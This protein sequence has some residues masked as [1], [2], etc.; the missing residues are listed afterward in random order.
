VMAE[1]TSLPFAADCLRSLSPGSREP[2][3]TAG[4]DE[5]QTKQA[6]AV[7]AGRIGKD[8]VGNPDYARH[9]RNIGSLMWLWKTYGSADEMTGYLTTRFTD[10]PDEAVKFLDAFIGRAY[11]LENGLSHKSTFDRNDFDNVALLVAPDVV[12]N[13]LEKSYGALLEAV[14][15]DKC[16]ELHGDEQTACRF[17]AIF[18]NVQEDTKSQAPQ[19]AKSTGPSNT[20]G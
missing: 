17:A 9:G 8:I 6:G 3:D 14:T 7:L 12:L 18:A 15:F 2:G 16:Y 13:A 11:G 4:L 1:A 20:N 5:N 19:T 10:H